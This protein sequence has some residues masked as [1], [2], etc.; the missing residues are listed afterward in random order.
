M[1]ALASRGVSL[2]ENI[3]ATWSVLEQAQKPMFGVILV[4]SAI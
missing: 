3:V 1:I 4:D 2:T